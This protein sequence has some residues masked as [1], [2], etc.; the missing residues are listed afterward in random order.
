MLNYN[1]FPS[2]SLSYNPSDK[3]DTQNSKRNNPWD[4]CAHTEKWKL[5]NEISFFYFFYFFF[6][7]RLASLISDSHIKFKKSWNRLNDHRGKK[8]K[9]NHS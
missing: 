8:H 5:L 9:R 3:Y 6:L 2:E 1:I 7:A 4:Q